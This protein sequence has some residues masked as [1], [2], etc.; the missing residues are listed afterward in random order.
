MDRTME[1]WHG[2]V[3]VTFVHLLAA[4][5]PGP[6][7]A[8]VIKQ[9]IQHGRSSGLWTSVGISLGL[10]IHI[11]YSV[12]GLAA[13]VAHSAQWM[14]IIKL[15]GGAYLIYLGGKGLLSKPQ[16]KGETGSLPAVKNG[17][18]QRCIMTGFICNALNPK[19]PIYF[20]SLFTVI[21]SPEMPLPNLI[22]YGGW[23]MFLQL[24]WFSA[25]ALVLTK[26][27]IRSRIL[28]AGHWIERIFGVAMV[29]LGA[30]VLSSTAN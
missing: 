28:R 18:P 16:K 15:T 1:F 5:S 26:N 10:S 3:V 19:A 29:A 6:D 14:F 21:L 25:L 9:S 20:L 13:I 4:A 2:F 7:F 8:L 12:V 24:F 22:V 17:S 11:I 27:A 30:K 23:I